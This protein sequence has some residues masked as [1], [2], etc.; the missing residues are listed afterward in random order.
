MLGLIAALSFSAGFATSRLGDN[1]RPDIAQPP[2]V[3]V[4]PLPQA[5]SSGPPIERSTT[6]VAATV[7]ATVPTSSTTE[8]APEPAFPNA[9]S[10]GVDPDASL[11]LVESRDRPLIVTED[12]D[13]ISYTGNIEIGADGVTISNSRIVATTLNAAVWNRNGHSNVTIRDST[14]IC[15]R[16]GEPGAAGVAGIQ[17]VFGNDIS[18]CADG[19]KAG[20]GAHI[21]GNYIHDL[22]FG[23]ATHN[24]GI[25]IQA[26][27]DIRIVNNTIIT[28]TDDPAV[29]QANAGVFAQAESGPIR[30][31][32]IANNY[33][34]G[35]GFSLRIRGERLSD[36]K[37]V[38]NV[39]GPGHFFGALLVDGGAENPAN[40]NL[41]GNNYRPDGSLI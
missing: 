37:I 4:T 12:L 30:R 3:S 38:D 7:Q 32:T 35:F 21:R 14:I 18:G 31:L 27:D 19:I 11:I 15:F 28:Y 6:T 34:D 25:Q 20:G 8:A 26:G 16:E 40:N 33:V 9:S 23:E 39:I 29:R 5:P 41:V 13:G 36:S 10:T 2:E 1:R 24:D 17:N 22:G